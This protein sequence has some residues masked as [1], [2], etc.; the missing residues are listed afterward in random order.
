MPRILFVDDNKEYLGIISSVLNK[1]GY[2]VVTAENGI[3]AIDKFDE[4]SFD[5]VV[6]DLI[7]PGA[8]GYELA[9]YIR[10][11]SGDDGTPAIICITGTSC[12]IDRRSFDVFLEKPFSIKKL[13]GYLKDFENKKNCSK[14][15]NNGFL[16]Y[17][18]V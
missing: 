6:T 4:S 3:D 10:D 14:T 15:R 7:M 5:A 18:H 17:G 13:I 9:K 2:D 8:N 1:V 12:D 16:K 11:T